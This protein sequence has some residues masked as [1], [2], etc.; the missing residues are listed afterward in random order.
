MCNIHEEGEVSAV[1]T[2]KEF[3]SVRQVC[4]N[5]DAVAVREEEEIPED[6]TIG[7]VAA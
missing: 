4:R 2:L 7:E 1:A 5:L 6:A 3:L